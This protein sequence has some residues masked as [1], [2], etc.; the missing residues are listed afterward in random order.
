M[1]RGLC[2]EAAAAM[3][4]LLRTEDA[5]NVIN[6][7]LIPILD[8]IGKRYEDGKIYL[9][10]L[11]RSAE[12]A[13]AACDVV[14]AALPAAENSSEDIVVLATVHGDI[15]DIGKNIVRSVLENYG[16]R[17][18]DLGR[19]VPEQT[20]VDAVIKSG[21][22]LCGL[23][24]LMTTTVPAMEQTI[25]LLNE[26]GSVLQ[27]G[28]RRCRSDRRLCRKN[29]RGLLFERCGGNGACGKEVYGRN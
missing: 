9:P 17:I 25:K 20:V 7:E 1:E 5:Q 2:D 14:R 12:A 28:C 26:A 22:K 21:A 18:I 19:D 15:H 16:F 13:R 29:R 4:T 27:N 24:A 3:K 10:Q 8:N 23:S 6:T 11:M